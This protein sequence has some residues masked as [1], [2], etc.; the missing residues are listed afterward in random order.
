[1]SRI[2]KLKKKVKEI[3]NILRECKMID[4]MTVIFNIKKLFFYENVKNLSIKKEVLKQLKFQ[5]NV[6]NLIICQNF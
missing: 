5:E 1:M 4:D 3:K 2:C 6:K